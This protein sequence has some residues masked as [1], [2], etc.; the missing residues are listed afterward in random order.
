[1][2]R[3]VG[4]TDIF[5]D[6]DDYHDFVGRMARVLPE[7]GARCFGWALMTNHAHLVM[8]TATG[9]LS[10]VMR[11]LATGHAVRFNRRHGRRGYVFMDRFRSRI[12]QSDAD[13]VG[14]VRYVHRNPIEAGIVRSLEVL[15]AYPWSGHAAL[16]G[17][18]DPLPFE[19]VPAALSLFDDD[20]GRARAA[21]ASWMACEG[22]PAAPE[23]PGGVMR[24]EHPRERASGAEAFGDLRALLVAACQRYAVTPHELSS[25]GKRPRVARARAAV[26]YVAVMK[27]GESGADVARALG[28]SRTTVSGLL[29]RGRRIATEDDFSLVSDRVR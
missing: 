6:A 21:L 17:A 2:L 24:D 26:A 27:L 28:V 13:L 11:R 1:M 22:A 15:A 12:V 14:L 3:G 29:D 8:Q 19:D 18:R 25:G 23:A 4:G 16:V 20:P 10:R 5:L 7:C 9:A